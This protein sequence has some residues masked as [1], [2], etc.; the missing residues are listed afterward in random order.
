MRLIEA[1]KRPFGDIKTLLIGTVVSLIPIV[2]LITV[3]YYLETGKATINR[4][5][6]AL[7]FKQVGD[8][9]VKGLLAGI[10]GLA[11]LLPAIIVGFSSLLTIADAV[12]T[13]TLPAF[14]FSITLA[15]AII[16][17]IIALYII[18]AAVLNYVTK[19]K[20]GAAFEFSVISK[21]AFNS[22]YFAAWLVGGL[23]NIVLTGIGLL[24]AFTLPLLGIPILG[25]VVAGFVSF[26]V[27]VTFYTLIGEAWASAK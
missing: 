23:Y 27:G 8:M 12:F 2:S 1:V 3:G 4:N 14:S 20:L 21:K 24:A 22:K 17:G 6:K 15:I 10:I 18:P 26:L 9:F 11:Y 13:N 19:G 16:L 7:E 25:I 5:Y